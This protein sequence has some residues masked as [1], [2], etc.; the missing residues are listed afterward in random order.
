MRLLFSQV[1]HPISV[2]TGCQLA[3]YTIRN[4]NVDQLKAIVRKL[5]GAY[6][7]SLS[8]RARK[9]QELVDGLLAALQ[10]LRDSGNAEHWSR[11]LEALGGA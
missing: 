9:K 4:S 7:T 6:T 5:D 1:V 2:S 10:E 3:R 8:Q 11:F